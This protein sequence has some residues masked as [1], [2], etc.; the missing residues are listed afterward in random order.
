MSASTSYNRFCLGLFSWHRS[1]LIVSLLAA[2]T[3]VSTLHALTDEETALSAFYYGAREY[4]LVT[5]GDY[6]SHGQDVW[7]SIAVGGNFTDT[8]GITLL[9][10]KWCLPRNTNRSSTSDPSVIVVGSLNFGGKET[11]LNFGNFAYNSATNPSAVISGS[12]LYP[13]GS[14]KDGTV[15]HV[16]INSG[17]FRDLATT[18]S[19]IDFTALKTKLSSAQNF[20]KTQST[21]ATAQK[22][23]VSTDGSSKT[24]ISATSGEVSYLDLNANQYSGKDLDFIV[25]DG[26]ALVINLHVGSTAGN[27]FN[28]NN[29]KIDGNDGKNAGTLTVTSANRILWNVVFD[30]STYNTLVVSTHDLYGSFLTTEGTIQANG[31]IWGQVVANS[32]DQSAGYELHQSLLLIEVPEPS[33]IALALGSMALGYAAWR[34]RRT[35]TKA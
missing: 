31:R 30:D 32:F 24:T 8:G 17:S 4:N 6:T 16:T 28:P 11:K 27:K 20:L 2:L 3:S 33:T 26:S 34:R 21:N 9:N 5:F 14:A 35:A 29:V 7:G 25:S 23:S 12:R 19:V 22:A 13:Q 15:G 10:E 1:T 18:P